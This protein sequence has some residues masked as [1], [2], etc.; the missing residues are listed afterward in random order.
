M[1]AV[2]EE[3]SQGE[4]AGSAARKRTGPWSPIYALPALAA[5]AGLGFFVAT[6][7]ASS[8]H[9]RFPQLLSAQRDHARVMFCHA[10]PDASLRVIGEYVSSARATGDDATAYGVELLAQQAVLQERTKAAAA[11][12]SWAKAEKACH[13]AGIAACGREALRSLAESACGKV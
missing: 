1:Q 7:L 6:L 9:A 4:H 11:E 8:A 2:S 10:P 3:W 5:G 12:A 13:V